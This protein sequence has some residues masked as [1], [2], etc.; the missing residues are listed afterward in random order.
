MRTLRKDRLR[1]K[2]E[3]VAEKHPQLLQQYE[4]S[5]KELK[6]LFEKLGYKL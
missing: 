4:E 1:Y 3:R 2:D 6:D 5:T